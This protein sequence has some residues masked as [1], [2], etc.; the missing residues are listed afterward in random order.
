MFVQRRR[1]RWFRPK[2]ATG[3]LDIEL[4]AIVHS[5]EG[6][7]DTGIPLEQRPSVDEN[8]DPEM[9]TS[10][11]LP[12]SLPTVTPLP[13]PEAPF[14][15][16]LSGQKLV[17]LRAQTLDSQRSQTRSTLNVPQ[18]ETTSSANAA[19]GVGEASSSFD[20]QRLHS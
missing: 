11:S 3:P 14:P 12:S 9:I 4:H 19:T 15:V 18:P 2:S 13:Q 7:R 5:S 16:G 10:Y 8:P 17:Q 1:R 6:T 20:P